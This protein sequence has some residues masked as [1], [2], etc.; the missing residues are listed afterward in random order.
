MLG[1]FAHIV[2][3]HLYHGFG[4]AKRARD[5][6]IVQDVL[7]LF[8]CDRSDLVWINAL[9]SMICLRVQLRNDALA[10]GRSASEILVVRVDTFAIGQ[11]GI[12][13]LTVILT[14]DAAMLT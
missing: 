3:A 1:H 11:G 8:I 7:E 10:V 6:R 2:V 4:L 14:S 13:L 12:S 5:D 9:T